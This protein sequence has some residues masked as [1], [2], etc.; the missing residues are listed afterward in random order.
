MKVDTESFGRLSNKE[1]AQLFTL[2]NSQGIT[3]KLTN[4]GGTIISVL[5]PD[6]KG[7]LDDVVLGFDSLEV[8]WYI[9]YKHACWKICKSYRR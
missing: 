4:F 5:V 3:V 2:Q 9:P 6:R 7:K 1:D 8:A